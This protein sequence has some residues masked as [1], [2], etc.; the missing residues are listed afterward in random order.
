MAPRQPDG[1]SSSAWAAARHSNFRRNIYHEKRGY[2]EIYERNIE[3]EK[4]A[5][6]KAV[7]GFGIEAKNQNG[8][9]I[10]IGNRKMMEQNN[11]EIKSSQD[12][13]S[14]ISE[15]KQYIICFNK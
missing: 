15:R 5:D 9:K 2:L 14:L 7:A 8:D 13:Q 11:I 10:L 12:E 6:F 3:L 4:I 1:I